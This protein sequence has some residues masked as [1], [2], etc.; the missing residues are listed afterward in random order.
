M[1]EGPIA[2]GSG[3]SRLITVVSAPTAGTTDPTEIELRDFL[4]RIVARLQVEDTLAAGESFVFRHN[5]FRVDKFTGVDA[6]VAA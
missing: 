6:K 3:P 2:V 1:G 5:N 4:G